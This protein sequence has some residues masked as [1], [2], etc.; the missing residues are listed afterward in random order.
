LRVQ[1]CGSLARASFSNEPKRVAVRF[2]TVQSVSM[3]KFV[4][5]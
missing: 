2:T 1:A 4:R 5:R 3:G